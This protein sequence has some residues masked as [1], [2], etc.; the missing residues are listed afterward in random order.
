MHQVQALAKVQ[1]CSLV[2]FLQVDVQVRSSRVSG[3]TS[4]IQ[5]LSLLNGDLLVGRQHDVHVLTFAGSQFFRKNCVFV[6]AMIT[7][8]GTRDHVG[9]QY[10][11]AVE[12][13][14]IRA[15]GDV[16]IVRI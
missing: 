9:I 4:S 13:R 16:V 14:E 7:G 6:G 10:A 8:D 3:V 12:G 1:R 5:A 11:G 2:A 15:V